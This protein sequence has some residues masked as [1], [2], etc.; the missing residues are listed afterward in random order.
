MSSLAKQLAEAVR[1]PEEETSEDSER[2]R[3][4]LGQF[5][6]VWT[7]SGKLVITGTIQELSPRTRTVR[8]ADTGSGTD[9]QIDVDPDMYEVWV[10]DMIV[11]GEAPTPSKQP[12]TNLRGTNPGAATLGKRY[13]VFQA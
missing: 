4:D 12:E 6:E 1:E 9:V 11:P 10:M 2:V 8:V 3:L 13:R 7:R 5:V